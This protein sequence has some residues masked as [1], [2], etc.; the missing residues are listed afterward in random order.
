MQDQGPVILRE[1]RVFRRHSCLK[2][3]HFQLF[4]VPINPCEAL[5]SV[6]YILC[7]TVERVS[8]GCQLVHYYGTVCQR[9]DWTRYKASY[10]TT[11]TRLTPKK[12]TKKQK[13][14]AKRSRNIVGQHITFRSKSSMILARKAEKSASWSD[15]CPPEIIQ[16]YSSLCWCQSQAASGNNHGDAGVT[17]LIISATESHT[18]VVSYLVSVN[19]NPNL[20]C[21]AGYASIHVA[22]V[23]AHVDVVRLLPLTSLPGITWG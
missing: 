14:E 2:L 21:D 11:P 4:S 5:W 19:A 12:G 17:P 1:S 6:L 10:R 13:Q 8:Y 7:G 22:V 20:C 3:G 16:P 18:H 15:V 23:R 9:T